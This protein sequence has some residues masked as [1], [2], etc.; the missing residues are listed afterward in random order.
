MQKVCLLGAI[1]ALRLSRSVMPS[2]PNLAEIKT[3]DDPYRGLG[4]DLI[5]WKS[6]SSWCVTTALANVT[7]EPEPGKKP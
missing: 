2:M 5:V 4:H 7:D 1:Q 3:D 6:E